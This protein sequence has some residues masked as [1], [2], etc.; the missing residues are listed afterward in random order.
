MI[1]VWH[2]QVVV[3]YHKKDGVLICSNLNHKD[4]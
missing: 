1:Y 3:L 2:I 4:T